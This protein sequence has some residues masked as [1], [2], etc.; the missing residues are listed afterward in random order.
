MSEVG[1]FKVLSDLLAHSLRTGIGEL[2]R[3]IMVTDMPR[4]V[5]SAMRPLVTGTLE[6]K[7]LKH[8][9]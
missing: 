3:C 4:M 2:E 1:W 5:V 7:N 8:I 6:E 9:R